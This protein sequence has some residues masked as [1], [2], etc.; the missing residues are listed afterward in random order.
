[1]YRF[2]KSKVLYILQLLINGTEPTVMVDH[3][4]ANNFRCTSYNEPWIKKPV[5]FV[6]D[7]KVHVLYDPNTNIPSGAKMVYI[8]NPDDFVG[9]INSDKEFAL[10]DT[11][12]EEL[13]SLAIVFALENVESAR[14]NTKLNTRGLES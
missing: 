7:N 13:I 4:T 8:K 6:E 2:D 14:L 11:V 3:N 9:N 12:A 1:M 5:F 10:T